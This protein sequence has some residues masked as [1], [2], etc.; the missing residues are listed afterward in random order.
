MIEV[1]DS[2][3]FGEGTPRSRDCQPGNADLDFDFCL[4]VK[5]TF[6]SL[7]LLSK[8]DVLLLDSFTITL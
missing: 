4:T 5:E 7:R 3:E 2:A 6:D 8:E 1:G